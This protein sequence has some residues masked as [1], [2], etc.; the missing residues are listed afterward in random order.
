MQTQAAGGA[1]G[2]K[3]LAPS[4]LLSQRQLCGFGTQLRTSSLCRQG[5]REGGG[6]AGR[7]GVPSPP[8]EVA[9]N[10]PSSGGYSLSVSFSVQQWEPGFVV[11]ALLCVPCT[12]HP[13]TLSRHRPAPQSGGPAGVCGPHTS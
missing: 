2:M 11:C 1:A 7:A 12:P 6:G 9:S 3:G 13:R 4:R 5:A 8:W 10:S